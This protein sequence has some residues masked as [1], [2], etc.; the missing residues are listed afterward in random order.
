MTIAA[1]PFAIQ[2]RLVFPISSPPR[3]DCVVTIARDRIVA[4]GDNQSGKPAV[5]LGDVAILPGLVNPHTHLEFSDLAAPL[6][7]AGMP[8]PDWITAVVRWKRAAADGLVASPRSDIRHARMTGLR[9]CLTQG[10]TT[11]GDIVSAELDDVSWYQFPITWYAFREML[12]YSV[13]T[14]AQQRDQVHRHAEQVAAVAGL[15][16]H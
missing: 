14:R 11:V 13:E 2:A 10:V 8:F 12:G 6:G 5:D 7:R 15:R 3:P 9:E 1:Q 16:G 4:V